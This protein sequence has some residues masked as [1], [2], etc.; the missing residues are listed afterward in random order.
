LIDNYA[1]IISP[2]THLTQKNKPWSWT[3]DC[4]VVFDNIKEAFIIALILGHWDPESLMI[5]ETN[6]SDHVL[7]AIL[8]T[9]FNGEICPIAFHLRAFSTAE[10]N[11]DVHNKELLAIIKSFKKW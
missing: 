11:Y 4:E 1:E 9:Q 7:A 5:L 2:L 6:T 3:T 8:S 10:I